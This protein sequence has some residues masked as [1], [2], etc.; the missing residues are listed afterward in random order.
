MVNRIKSNV[1]T[2]GVSLVVSQ[3]Y[4]YGS[5]FVSFFLVTKSDTWN[6]CVSYLCGWMFS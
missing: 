5:F 6:S 1:S 2:R 4:T 3:I